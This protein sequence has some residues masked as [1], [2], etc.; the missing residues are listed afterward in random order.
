MYNFLLFYDPNKFKKTEEKIEE[1]T[2][3]IVKK[4]NI[5]FLCKKKKLTISCYL[6]LIKILIKNS[7]NLFFVWFLSLFFFSYV[8]K[9]K[10]FFIFYFTNRP[11]FKNFL[12]FEKFEKKKNIFFFKKKHKQTLLKFN[13][14]IIT[15]PFFFT[16]KNNIMVKYHAFYKI[17]YNTNFWFKNFFF[18]KSFFKKKKDFES[19]IFKKSSSFWS[20]FL[21]FAFFKENN[22]FFFQKSLLESHSLNKTLWLENWKFFSF[23]KTTHKYK[24][25]WNFI[26]NINLFFNKK[27]IKKNSSKKNQIFIKFSNFALNCIKKVKNFI[28]ISD[29]F[30]NLTNCFLKFNIKKDILNY[31]FNLFARKL[32]IKK[33]NLFLKKPINFSNYSLMVAKKVL[34]FFPK[35]IFY[36]NFMWKKYLK[37]FYRV[38]KKNLLFNKLI[39]NLKEHFKKKKN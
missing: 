38:T 37:L 5:F 22:N 12:F 36:Y 7:V 3:E 17:Y 16:E 28:K 39:Y 8:D 34:K 14:Y 4:K 31:L 25:H 29:I 23:L 33:K 30:F 9:N 15:S 20:I 24:L 1:K 2:K 6:D 27:K 18:S 11:I 13:K 10:L 26:K 21:N 35:R 32:I 19:F